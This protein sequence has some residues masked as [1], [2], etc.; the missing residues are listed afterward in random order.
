MIEKDPSASQAEITA[1]LD[2]L[3]EAQLEVFAFVGCNELARRWMAPR[4]TARQL[5]ELS[6]KAQVLM[7]VNLRG[8]PRLTL[9]L[10]EGGE[11]MPLVARE[12]GT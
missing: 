1:F 10:H 12:P 11:R 2:G 3:T 7:E 5:V 6:P 8:S 4:E 9:W